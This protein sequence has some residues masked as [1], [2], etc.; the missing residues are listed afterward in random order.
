MKARN[1]QVWNSI[2][3]AQQ[4]VEKLWILPF[5]P[6]WGADKA[7]GGRISLVDLRLTSNAVAAPFSAKPFGL[8]SFYLCAL[9]LLPHRSLQICSVVASRAKPKFLSAAV[10]IVFQ[11]AATA[12]RPRARD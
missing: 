11:Q 8:R 3:C 1:V 12:F 5:R 9:S 10:S 7:R 6:K 4:P 2:A